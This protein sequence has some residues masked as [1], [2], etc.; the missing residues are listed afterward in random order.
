MRAI[1][2][3]VWG[4]SG[5]SAIHA[6]AWK[7]QQSKD[8]RLYD[9][10]RRFVHSMV[11]VLP[12]PKCR[13]NL[14]SHLSILPMPASTSRVFRWSYLLH[15][16]VNASTHK[17]PTHA[18]SYEMAKKV[19]A[20]SPARPWDFLQAVA[21][22]HPGARLVDGGLLRA[23][24]DFVEGAHRLFGLD[25]CDPDACASRARLRAWLKRMH[26]PEKTMKMCA[27]ETCSIPSR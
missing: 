1:D 24:Q 10:F 22:T 8:E 4:P 20:G 6:A 11:R 13:D 2:P 5:W 3:A 18:P 26:V 15:L 9:V 7:V 14:S 16:R 17:P 19:A 12:C 21:H 27:E 23:Y 25:R